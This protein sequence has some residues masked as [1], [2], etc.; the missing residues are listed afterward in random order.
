KRPGRH[1]DR[2]VDERIG[3][4]QRDQVCTGHRGRGVF[5]LAVVGA[6]GRGERHRADCK[7]KSAMFHPV[8][9]FCCRDELE[10]GHSR[11][12]PPCA[13]A[14]DRLSTVKAEETYGAAGLHLPLS[15]GWLHTL[16]AIAWST[17]TFQSFGKPTGAVL[18][19]QVDDGCGGREPSVAAS[20]PTRR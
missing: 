18:A 12:A 5:P 3:Q 17:S 4:I 16:L 10:T 15:P 20:G 9:L 19:A 13:A 14:R 8:L 7:G 2:G 11:P 1:F 6:D